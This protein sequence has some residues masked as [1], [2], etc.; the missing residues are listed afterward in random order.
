MAPVG[1]FLYFQEVIKSTNEDWMDISLDFR[2][3][4]CSFSTL[5]VIPLL[6]LISRT[7]RKQAAPS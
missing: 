6:L 2:D 5:H 1:T 7:E 3:S 4:M